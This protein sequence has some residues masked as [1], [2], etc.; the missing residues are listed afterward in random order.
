[1]S[2]STRFSSGSFT[3]ARASS[4]KSKLVEAS[5]FSSMFK[6]AAFPAK[7]GKNLLGTLNGP[8]QNV[9]LGANVGL[10]K[11]WIAAIFLIGTW[12]HSGVTTCPKK[13]LASEK[14]DIHLIST[15]P[16]NRCLA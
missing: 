16:L 5:F 10:L 4:F 2:G 11:S 12:N 1:M 14:I 13:S 6:E 8:V 15:S 7:I 3:A 9:V